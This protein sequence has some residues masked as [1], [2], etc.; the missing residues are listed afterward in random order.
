MYYKAKKKYTL[1]SSAFLK[2]K[3]D[4]GGRFFSLFFISSEKNEGGRFFFI[5]SKTD[6]ACISM[7]CYTLRQCS[8]GGV[9]QPM[10]VFGLIQ[11]PCWTKNQAIFWT[12]TRHYKVR[13]M[14]RLYTCTKPH[15]NQY[16]APTRFSKDLVNI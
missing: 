16:Q 3:K 13:K 1:K 9:P 6:E 11:E 4:E 14:R 10:M 7:S 12:F 2:K 15:K 8:M 5:S